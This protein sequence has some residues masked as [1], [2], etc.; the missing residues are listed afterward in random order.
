MTRW[1]HDLDVEPLRPWWLPGDLRL[2][3]RGESAWACV[4]V[5]LPVILALLALGLAGELFGSEGPG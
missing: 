1:E 2:T 3:K 4:L 5:L